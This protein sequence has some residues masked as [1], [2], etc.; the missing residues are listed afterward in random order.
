LGFYDVRLLL[1]RQDPLASF[2]PSELDN[3]EWNP[4]PLPES[5][6]LDHGIT[7]PIKH[8]NKLRV[9]VLELGFEPGQTFL[10]LL[11]QIVVTNPFFESLNP[12]KTGEAIVLSLGLGFWLLVRMM[13]H[14]VEWYGLHTTA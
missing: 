3:M 2:Q 13:L 6:L 9:R 11:R 1:F 14:L 10:G 7:L 5:V 8:A 12:L 4:V